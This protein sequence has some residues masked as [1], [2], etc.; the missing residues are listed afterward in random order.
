[1]KKYLLAATLV[2]ACTSAANAWWFGKK[3]EFDRQA[4]ADNGTMV[5][6][7]GIAAANEKENGSAL[8]KDKASYNLQFVQKLC[9]CLSDGIAMRGTE[10]ELRDDMERNVISPHLND[11]SAEIAKECGRKI[12][13]Q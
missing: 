11:L 3:T 2:F 8:F 9:R 1:M 13:P 12:L 5:C 6:I 10:K 4:Y 7:E